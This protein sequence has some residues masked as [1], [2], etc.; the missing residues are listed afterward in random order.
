MSKEN[1]STKNNF[2]TAIASSSGLGLIFSKIY[3]MMLALGLLLVQA[4]VSFSQGLSE[5]Y[6]TKNK[7]DESYAYSSRITPLASA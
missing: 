5:R 2:G 1:K 4:S 3:S 6:Q 7:N